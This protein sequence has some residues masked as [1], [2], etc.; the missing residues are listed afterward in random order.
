MTFEID[1]SGRRALVTGAGQ[2]VGRAIAMRLA[3]AGAHV[4]V[5]DY[6]GEKADAVA[7]EIT[8][9]G[10]S[11][12]PSQ[13]D[14]TDLDQVR[15]AVAEGGPVDILVNNAGNAGTSNYTM[16][17]FHD[18]DPAVWERYLGVNLYGVMNMCHSV[19]PGMIER[20]P[21]GR[22]VNIVSDA[23]RAGEP[24]LA[25]YSAAKGGAASFGRALAKEVGRYG[26]NVNNLALG[27]I[28][29]TGAMTRDEADMTPEQQQAQ[30]A[31]MRPYI[32]RRMG[33]PDDVA[34]MVTF[35]ASGWADWITAQTIPVNGGYTVNQ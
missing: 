33:R 1:L 34:G 24:R 14:V 2:S 22:I 5:N 19:L 32:I 18:E 13:F 26:I 8:D 30:K 23:A 25:V 15:R 10:G 31:R 4:V 16:G 29:P 20:A 9:A 12:A 28:D 17:M 27:S 21:G 3:E 35:L 11:A 7:G 6:V